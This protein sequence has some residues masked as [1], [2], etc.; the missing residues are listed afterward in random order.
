M[1]AHTEG[2][3]D[4]GFV[5]GLVAGTVVGAGLTIW[6]APRAASELRE[7]A[8]DSAKRLGQQASE[9]L[10]SASTHVA[11]AVEDLK[12]AGQ[13]VRNDVAGAVAR[14]AREVERYATAAAGPSR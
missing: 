4:Y 12:Q 3:R 13:G 8:R 14:S 2:H 10:Q 9:R 6:L 11:D 7:R 5:L 1:D